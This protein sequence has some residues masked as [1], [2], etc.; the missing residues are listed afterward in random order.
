MADAEAILE[1]AREAQVNL[2]V[3]NDVSKLPL[4]FGVPSKDTIT[5]RQ[6]VQRVE[7]AIVATGWNDDQTMSFVASSLH[8]EAH[9]W[10]QVL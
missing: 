2:M 10:F 6:W 4:W 3:R 9:D 7:R 8:G 5:G 1:A